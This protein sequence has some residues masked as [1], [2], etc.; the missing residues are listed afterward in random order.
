MKFT[1][2]SIA[3]LKLPP[4]KSDRL[5]FSDDVPGWGFR[6]R[7]RR[8]KWVLQYEVVGKDGNLH[9]RRLTFGTYPAMGVPEARRKAAAFHAEVMLG[10]DPQGNKED[11]KARA[12]ETFEACAK[13]Y[14]ERRR[15]DVKLRQRSYG[16]IER[17]LL[18]NLE[19]LHAL[20]I[21]KLDRRAIALELARF[22]DERGPV[23]ANRTRASLV[24]FLNWCVG[25]GFIDANPATFTN[26]NQEAARD[27][28]LSAG[29]LAKVWRGLGEGD[30]ADIV[31]LLILLGQR[32]REI[33]D[34]CW[35]EIDLDRGVITL[36][37]A[38]TKNRRAHTIPLN[39]PAV[40]ILRA[41]S[42]IDGRNLVFG[43]GKGDRG[44][45]GWSR[46]KARLDAAVQIPAWVIHDLR[47]SFSTGLGDLGVA[48]HTI[49]M[50]LNHQSGT[51][52]GVSGR[53]NKSVYEREA[54]QAV[55]LWASTIMAAVEGRES[56]VVPL[57]RAGG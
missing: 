47:R 33:G 16:E 55:D 52:A 50:L 30:Y 7:T 31:R 39:G 25:E 51:K 43:R 19:K 10:G 37:P 3:A 36:P 54:R 49:E 48:P 20:R 15:N 5:V 57:Q 46:A 17:H 38:R 13:I 6:L 26:K 44:F 22:T 11:S 14:L 4:G 34:L 53:Y 18:R 42:Q 9:T 2:D 41:R 35:D 21:D 40:A 32:E 45:S 27:R 8:K 29:E 12:R 28:V 24:K 1:V 56:N 23:Q